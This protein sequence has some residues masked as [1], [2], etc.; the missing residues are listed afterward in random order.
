M[1]PD[2]GK[3]VVVR[4]GRFG[5]YVTDGVVNASLPNGR[6]PATLTLE[7]GLDLLALRAQRMREQGIEP[8][9]ARTSTRRTT[10][11]T[12]STRSAATKSAGTRTAKPRATTTKSAA[13]RSTTPR[14]PGATRR[15]A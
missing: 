9:T 10:S 1:H 14:R 12:T 11:K 8:G 2:S 7:E 3:P 4:S 15:S 5:P 6:N 13:T